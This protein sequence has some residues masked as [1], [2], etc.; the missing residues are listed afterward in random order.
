MTKLKGFV[1]GMCM[2]LMLGVVT[3]CGTDN[4]NGGT[5]TLKFGTAV[6]KTHGYYV[7]MEKFKEVLE[8]K[9][10][11]QVQVELYT[12]GT[13]GDEREL[14]EGCQMNSVDMCISSNAVLAAFVPET[15]IF[16]LP[17]L[18]KDT[19]SK[20]AVLE[21]KEIT[22]ALDKSYESAGLKNMGYLQDDFR[23][24]MNS[25]KPINSLKDC[26]GVKLRTMES[27]IMVDVYNALGFEV[28]TM[29]MSEAMTAVQNG[30]VDG[31]DYPPSLFVSNKYYEICKYFTEANVF[32]FP[33]PVIMN[34]NTWN[35]L[36]EE[37]QQWVDEAIKEANQY[38]KDEQIKV[39]SE[40]MG[41]LKENGVKFTSPDMAE[42][43]KAV[44]PVKDKYAKKFDQDLLKK[45]E[46]LQR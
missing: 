23:S 44:Q 2:L 28:T 8:E 9:S 21:N 1:M 38:Q 29:P 22:G 27:E 10:G 34:Q 40:A 32:S 25:K 18:F 7:C 15:D 33:S 16:S 11:G 37:Q 3:G 20:W 31:L 45:I 4:S 5:V 6:A 19:D 17:F 13:I 35:S 36:T 26:K 14:V 46:D 39:D 12:D 24:F 41:I 43:E 30:T 42:W